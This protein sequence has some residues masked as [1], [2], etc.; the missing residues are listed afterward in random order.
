MG[1]RA[2][3]YE[4]RAP[5]C[6]IY[7]ICICICKEIYMLN[8]RAAV[9]NV[10]LVG[11]AYLVESVEECIFLWGLCVKN[12]CWMLGM[13]YTH[14]IRTY[15][16]RMWFPQWVC[17]LCSTIYDALPYLIYMWLYVRVCLHWSLREVLLLLL[18]AIRWII[19]NILSGCRTHSRSSHP[20]MP[21]NT[22]IAKHINTWFCLLLN[23][24][25]VVSDSM[26][27]TNNAHNNVFT[28]TQSKAWMHACIII[29]IALT[30]WCSHRR[31]R[32]VN[33]SNKQ[34][35]SCV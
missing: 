10:R 32:V 1:S 5:K 20:D 8:G 35:L 19:I 25:H 27:S 7:I 17:R 23:A 14:S 13:L 4:M 2:C 15:M 9:L 3:T 30:Y 12:N 21:D 34:I 29:I 24:A 28:H 16:V 26:H 11:G 22:H 33:T 6:C 31:T 18:L